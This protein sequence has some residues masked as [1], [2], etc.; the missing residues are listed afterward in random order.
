ML[1][2]SRLREDGSSPSCPVTLFDVS[3]ALFVQTAS[4]HRGLNASAAARLESRIVR[5]VNGHSGCG[6]YDG[7]GATPECGFSRASRNKEDIV[8]QK[9]RIGS[10]CRKDLLERNGYLLFAC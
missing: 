9:R 4:L 3:S 7:L 1:L 5:R 2:A 8:G 6:L 10:L